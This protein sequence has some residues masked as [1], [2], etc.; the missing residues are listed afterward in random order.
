MLDVPP[1]ITTIGTDGVGGH[2]ALD[3]EVIEIALDLAVQRRGERRHRCPLRT[4]SADGRSGHGASTGLVGLPSTMTAWAARIPAAAVELTISPANTRS[5]AHRS[6]CQCTVRS[7]SS[8]SASG[9][10]TCRS[11]RAR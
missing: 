2:P 1:E 6:P 11:P 7:A 10:P 4:A 5:T 3:G 9:R 8:W